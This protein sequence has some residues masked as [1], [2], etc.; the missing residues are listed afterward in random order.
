MPVRYPWLLFDADDTLF[1]YGRAEAEAVRGAFAVHG[2]T[3]DEGWLPAYQAIN[4]RAW[5]ALEE[6]RVTPAR[7]RVL[8]FEELF[9]E[10][11]LALDPVAFSA[12]YLA[13]LAT[14]AHLVDGVQEVVGALR[15]DHRLAIITNGLSDVQ[16]ARIAASTLAG[17]VEH[18]VIS[19][20]VGAA[21]PDP[22]IFAVALARMG[23]P[24]PRDVLVIGDSL[25]SDI[26][27]GV[28]AGLATCWFN[29]GAKPRGDG[30]T[31]TYEI[32][33]LAEL[34]PLLQR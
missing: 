23:D 30:P 6:G 15:A 5:R 29:P 25:S 10:L 9:A 1:D 18:L 13:Q 11:G 26:A 20:E 16:R 3:F 19:E 21:K 8:R 31:P 7:P 17:V 34:L 2:F 32:R 27:G 24:D 33:R 14:Q 4:A 28:A 12:V 22:A